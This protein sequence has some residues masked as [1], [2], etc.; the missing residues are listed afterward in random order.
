[1][2]LALVITPYV[3]LSAMAVLLEFQLNKPPGACEAAFLAWWLEDIER[4]KCSLQQ[5]IG[6]YCSSFPGRVLPLL[7]ELLL[8]NEP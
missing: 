1:M 5:A 4:A 2:P 6:A 3:R 7:Q 8:H